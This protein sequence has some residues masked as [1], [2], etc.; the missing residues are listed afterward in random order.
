MT[1]KSKGDYSVNKA[2]QLL[3]EQGYLV[4]KALAVRFQPEDFFSCWDLIAI[5]DNHVR[6][7][8]VSRVQLYDRGA[9]YKFKLLAFPTPPNTTKEY[10]HH[11]NKGFDIQYLNEQ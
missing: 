8:Q 11:T 6:F 7:I 2:R 3:K 4:A 9:E 5:N 10:W 1:T